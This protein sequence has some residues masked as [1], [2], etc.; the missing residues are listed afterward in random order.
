MYGRCECEYSV[1]NLSNR[2]PCVGAIR[3]ASHVRSKSKRWPGIQGE[4]GPSSYCDLTR[5]GDINR[6]LQT[7]SLQASPVPGIALPAGITPR[8]PLRAKRHPLPRTSQSTSENGHTEPFQAPH[9]PQEKC[10]RET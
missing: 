8:N 4:L 3:S 1:Y 6:S 5:S 7:G 10:L 9:D 2:K